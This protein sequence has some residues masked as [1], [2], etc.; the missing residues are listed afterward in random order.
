[1]LY[2][3]EIMELL[4]VDQEVATRIFSWVDLDLSEC[5]QEEFDADVRHVYSQ[6][7]AGIYK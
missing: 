6:M 1:M 7:K 5:T 4:Q 2:I 3:R